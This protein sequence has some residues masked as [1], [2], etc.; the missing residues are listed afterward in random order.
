MNSEKDKWIIPQTPKS[1]QTFLFEEEG[2][3]SRGDILL[4]GSLI[5]VAG[6]LLNSHSVLG[7]HGSHSSHESHTSH[8]SSSYDY[9]HASH[10]SHVSHTS[11]NS[12][13]GYDD[14]SG[15][16]DSSTPSYNSPTQQTNPVPMEPTQTTQSQLITQTPQNPLPTPKIQG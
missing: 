2:N 11:H 9:G 6:V 10:A 1:I 4:I 8:A 7:A 13:Y 14:G 12:G 15:S 16:V 3:I 5:I